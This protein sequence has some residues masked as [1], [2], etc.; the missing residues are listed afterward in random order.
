MADR[1][2]IPYEQY[3]LGAPSEHLDAEDYRLLRAI[4]DYPYEWAARPDI[5]EAPID[6]LRLHE[7]ARR[8][9]VVDVGEGFLWKVTPEGH[10][11]LAYVGVRPDGPTR[12][13]YLR[14]EP[15]KPLNKDVSRGGDGAAR[16]S[17]PVLAETDPSGQSMFDLADA[18][19][20]GASSNEVGGDGR[21]ASPAR[22][23]SR[24][25]DAPP[26]TPEPSTAHSRGAGRA[27]TE[28]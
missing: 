7:M 14:G 16:R 4:R 21:R 18:D 8:G 22:N 5:Q 23:G 17:E 28:G 2:G 27:S 25:G 9:L 10:V 15:P 19:T 1:D 11:Q 13:V 12:G 20:N 6:E 24:S 3:P 26:Q